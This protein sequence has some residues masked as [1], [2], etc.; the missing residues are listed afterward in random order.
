[1]KWNSALYDKSHAFVFSYGEDL[2]SLLNPK[3]GE[4]ILDLG[5]GT[6]HLTNQLA[7]QGA[8]V[9]GFDSSPEMIAKA[10]TAY[11]EIAFHVMDGKTFSFQQKFD[12]IFSNA[13]LHWIP[14]AKQVAQNIYNHLNS[15][16]RMVIEFGGKGNNEK[17]LAALKRALINHGYSEQAKINFWYYPSIGEHATILEE[18]GFRVTYAAHFD[19]KT[20]LEGSEGMK[21]WFRM[22]GSNFFKGIEAK[23]QEQILD[24]VE[25]ALTPT[26]LENDKWYADYK[27]IRMIAIKN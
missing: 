11:P 24:E 19:R 15:D 5:C 7:S 2:I 18:V 13:V 8:S 27:R 23:V 17:M 1:M 6:G 16:G 14:E 22:F 12:A 20:P 3:P 21:N 4:H 9:V 25:A 10:Q 26:H